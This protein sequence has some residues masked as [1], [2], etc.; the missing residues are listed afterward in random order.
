[1]RW[2][3]RN[4]KRERGIPEIDP[5]TFLAV[6]GPLDEIGFVGG[7]IDGT[8]TKSVMDLDEEIAL[9]INSAIVDRPDRIV[10]ARESAVT[11][12]AIYRLS[13]RNQRLVYH[14]ATSFHPDNF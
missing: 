14:F 2:S 10:L 6:H 5:K 4:K 8:V 7:P 13:V 12:I 9:P 1:M 3:F 11:S